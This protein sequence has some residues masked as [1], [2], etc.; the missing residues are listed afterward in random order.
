M[1]TKDTLVSVIIVGENNGDD[2]LLNVYKNVLEGTHKNLD[3]IVSTFR[4]ADE[5]KEIQAKFAELKLDTRWVFHEPSSN[6]LKE[7]TDLAEGEVIFYKSCNNVLWYPRHITVHLDGFNSD[8]GTKWALSHTENRNVEQPDSPFNTLSFRIDNPPKPDQIVLDE[9]CH[10]KEVETDWSQC[11]T[12]KDGVPLFYAGYSVKQW[13]QAKH[14]GTIPPEITVIQWLN[15]GGSQAP[16]SNLEELYQQVG[17]PVK[18]E[19]EEDVVETEEGL[20]VIRS[21]PTIVG[22]FHLREFSENILKVVQD[23]EDISSIAVKRT[24]GMGDVVL[25]EP[26]I[27][28]LKEKYPNVP[29]TLYTAKPEIVEFF[30]NK[31]DKTELIDGNELVKDYLGEN[32]PEQV[33]IDLDL[34]YESR[35]NCQFI[36]AYAKVAG[37]EFDSQEDKYVELVSESEKLVDDKYVVVVADGSGWPGKS[38]DM[39]KYAEVVRYVKSMGYK[40]FEPGFQY[41]EESETKYRGCSL[42]ELVNLLAHCEFYIGADNGPMHIARGLNKPCVSINGAALTY[43]SNPNRDKIIYVENK[44]NGGY[45]VKHRTFFSMA[46]QGIT[47]VPVFEED[48]SSGLSSIDAVDVKNAIDK[49]FSSYNGNS[50]A[51]NIGGTLVKRDIAPGFIYYKDEDGSY[52][53]EKPFYHPDQRLNISQ[54][55]TEEASNLWKNNFEPV[56]KQ[57]KEDGF[58]KDASILDVGCN[59][60]IFINGL[61][62][63]GYKNVK[64]YDINRFSVENG[65]DKYKNIAD[66]IIIRDVTKDLGENEY[67]VILLSDILPYVSRPEKLLENVHKALKND[68]VVYLNNISIENDSFKYDPRGWPAI[69]NGE[70]ITLYSKQG[71]TNTLTKFG[72]TFEDY[73][74]WV[75]EQRTEMNF[76]KLRKT[77]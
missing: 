59:M 22:N 53:R 18:T 70:I 28:K 55:Y 6:F 67:D 72:F 23:T 69:G 3:V 66:N 65:K 15:A 17:T 75:E 43:L 11:I 45:G 61:D 33:K 46:E 49:L 68:G 60:G 31:P 19:I 14:R 64:G 12:E 58:D 56:F 16:Q 30:K 44:T 8:K 41:T 51:L 32:A 27:R 29:I 20:E 26:I 21:F 34:S 40:V 50:Y 9:V 48:P 62:S 47:F 54:I 25:V 37:V 10:A 74:M 77:A 38:W 4:N 57:I 2:E 76:L 52:H 36:D 1:Y 71:L 39:D 42:G 63:N 35:N 5:T 7:L 13:I 73:G 24:M